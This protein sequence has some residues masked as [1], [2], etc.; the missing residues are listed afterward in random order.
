M[1]S[2][3]S[4]RRFVVAAAA[5]AGATWFDVPRI[6][7]DTRAESTK[8]YGGFPM[9]IQSFTLRNFTGDKVL[10][11]VQNDL[12]LHYV[13][14]I[15]PHFGEQLDD[16]YITQMKA[17]LAAHDI[18]HSGQ[19]VGIS[20]N[21]ESNKKIF[22]FA[23]RNGLRQIIGDF[24]PDAHA[25]LSKLVADYDIRVGGHNHGPGN[26]W[27]KIDDL[28]KQIKDLDPRIGA[29]ADLGHYL[30]AGV[31]PVEA[32]RLYKG[33]LWGIHLKDHVSA[34]SGSKGTVLGKGV[35]DVKGV[36]KAL[37]EVG[38]PADGSLSLEYE[39]KPENPIE[40]VK[41]SLAAAAEAAQSVA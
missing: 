8:K 12:G 21:H 35:M 7:A 11:I 34:T 25:S 27:C 9:G 18:T 1:H 2:A 30:H 17:K 5:A 29:C 14:F 19:F 23:K 36:F 37:K 24:N 15:D 33:R 16:A 20:A 26:H 31:D 39:E 38:F 28:L 4:R 32:I 40:D 22:E 3:F 41:A 6:L 13:E 10:D